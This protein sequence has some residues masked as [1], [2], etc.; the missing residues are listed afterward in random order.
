MLTNGTSPNVKAIAKTMPPIRPA[1]LSCQGIELIPNKH[2]SISNNLI[3]A[4]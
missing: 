1:K 4:K 2:A 3:N